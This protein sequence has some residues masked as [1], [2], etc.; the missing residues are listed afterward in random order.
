M[1]YLITP[2]ELEDCTETELRS[3]FWHIMN[4]L[5][6]Q[7]QAAQEWPLAMASLDNIRVAIRRKQAKRNRFAPMI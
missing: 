4:D 1:T 7:Q 6:R 5:I 3:K 2:S